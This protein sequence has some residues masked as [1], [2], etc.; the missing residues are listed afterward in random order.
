VEELNELIV[1]LHGASPPVKAIAHIVINHRSA[2]EQCNNGVW[3]QYNYSNVG[4]GG[5]D[6]MDHTVDVIQ[7]NGTKGDNDHMRSDANEGSWGRS[8]EGPSLAQED[9]P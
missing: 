2:K 7:S 3:D 9:T 4:M 6:F 1:A 8:G 5:P